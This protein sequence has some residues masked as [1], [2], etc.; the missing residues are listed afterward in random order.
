MSDFGA[1]AAATQL[2]GRYGVLR[3]GSTPVRARLDVVLLAVLALLVGCSV[4]ADETE[5]DQP[6]ASTIS[7]DSTSTET[8]SPAATS[9]PS[10]V[11][12]SPTVGLVLRSDGLG[13]AGFGEPV[14][15]ALPE[16]TSA[17]GSPPTGDSTTTGE[18]PQGFGG[19][20]V[21]FVVFGRLTV[22]FSDG[23]YYR[24]DGVM[25][26]AG[27]T[28]AGTD[29]SELATPEGITLGS[30]VDDLRTAFGDQLRLPPTPDE[31]SGDWLFGVGPSELGF[32]GALSGPPTDGSSSV[33][34]LSAG[35]QSSC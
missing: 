28:L 18:M 20:A 12:P 30:T 16:L 3:A 15:T 26:F 8:T 13:V 29:P 33:T 11:E 2:V 35:A 24:D 23:D 14:D 31:C 5:A 22:I 21:R 6:T 32:E 10:T 34:R 17:V 1:L 9:T 27:W 19:T 4:E 25:H 7:P